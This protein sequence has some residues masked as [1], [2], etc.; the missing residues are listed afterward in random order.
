MHASTLP[1]L[2]AA[3][4]FLVGLYGVTTSR[5]FVQLVMCLSVT[6]SST[7]VLFL[8]VG[9][10]VHATAPIFKDVPLGT[11]AVDPVVQSLVLTDIVVGVV[12]SALILSLALQIHKRTGSLDP[13]DIHAMEG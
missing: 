13:D 10:R 12:V 3:W 11:R 1:Y 7:Y 8:Q 6:Q 9:Y 5:N 4:L 2:L